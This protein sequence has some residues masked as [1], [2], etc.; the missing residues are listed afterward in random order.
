MASVPTPRESAAGLLVWPS[1]APG[2][3][4]GA[5]TPF[6]LEVLN[7]PMIVPISQIANGVSGLLPWRGVLLPVVD[8]EV[9]FAEIA[10]T[11][12]TNAE[13]PKSRQ[14]A[15]VVETEVSAKWLAV[16][17]HSAPRRLLEPVGYEPESTRFS[18]SAHLL[19]G[20]FRRDREWLMLPAWE[21]LFA[22]LLLDA[23]ANDHMSNEHL[24]NDHATNEPSNNRSTP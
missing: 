12:A 23:A 8:L 17:M 2:I 24:S 15:A 3:W 13:A 4:V 5:A 14:I 18:R 1:A 10:E 20:S 21:R 6:V 9:V 19:W 7:D 11:R 22:K 16:S